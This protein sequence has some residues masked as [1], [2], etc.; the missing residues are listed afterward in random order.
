MLWVHETPYEPYGECC[1]AGRDG[2]LL[3]AELVKPAGQRFRIGWRS[4]Y[5]VA[6]T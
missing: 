4:G 6:E 1:S 5:A 2:E 3:S